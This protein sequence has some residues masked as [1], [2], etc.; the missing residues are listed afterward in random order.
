[1]EVDSERAIVISLNRT[2]AN[3]YFAEGLKK[4]ALTNLT[5]MECCPLVNMEGFV[6][7]IQSI[8]RVYFDVGVTFNTSS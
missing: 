8:E 7:P 1:M 6:E 2:V 5:K 4:I 3:M